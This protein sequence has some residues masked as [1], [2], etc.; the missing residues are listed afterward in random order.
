MKFTLNRKIIGWSL[1]IILPALFYFFSQHTKINWAIINFLVIFIAALVMWAFRLVPEYIPA[2]FIILA[3]MILGLVPA[4]IILSGYTSNSFF[5]ALSVF[6]IGSIIIQS[7]IFYRFSLFLLK[8]L[9]HKIFL[10]Q[11]V[12]FIL[13]IATTPIMT[14]QS[15]RI[16]M[17]VPMI[18]D[19][20]E[21]AHLKKKQRAVNGL[22]MAIFSGSIYFSMIFMTGK[23][24]NLVLYG[25]MP[26]QIKEQ[27]TWN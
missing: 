22:A 19:L 1:A 16:S 14:A 6:G 15:S 27:F 4:D 7:G 17:L 21:A 13:S 5:M 26:D 11:I 23:S 25:M 24:S 3:I 12:V 2:L 8:H 18:N 10:L 20:T 9:P